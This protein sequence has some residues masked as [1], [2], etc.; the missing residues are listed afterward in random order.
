MNSIVIILLAV[1]VP[2]LLNLILTPIVIRIAN[3]NQWF[4][5][6]NAR[7]IHT[8]NVSR[9]GGIGFFLAFFLALLIISLS[10]PTEAGFR[11]RF[12]IPAFGMLLVFGIGVIDDF[13][14]LKASLKGAVQFVAIAL[15]VGFGFMF[16]DVRIPALGISLKLWFVSYPL[17]FFWILGIINA[18]NLIDGMDGLAGGISMLIAVSYGIIMFISG[19]IMVG[20]VAFAL[21]GSLLG[22][23]VFNKPKA[24][25]FMGDGGAYFLGYMLAVMPIMDQWLGLRLPSLEEAGPHGSTSFLHAVT[26][27]LIPIA[28]TLAAMIRR[29]KK[30]QKISEPD[31]HHMHHKMLAKG[32]SNWQILLVLGGLQ[33]VLSA[34]VI[35][36]AL[37]VNVWSG[38]SIYISW[39][40]VT[41]F[42]VWLDSMHKRQ[43]Q[44]ASDK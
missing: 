19:S 28:D 10:L 4:D 18:I 25:I 41:F 33:L 34:A 5:R 20:V 42:F 6:L 21:A 44:A 8:G 36:D 24:K 9:L 23:L 27:L 1:L 39:L 13:Y 3:R 2:L 7:K 26:L 31:R 43:T 14:E 30:G 40:V 22:F 35:F 15:V 37:V 38:I 16:N 32:M 29:W 17:T 12:L 11:L